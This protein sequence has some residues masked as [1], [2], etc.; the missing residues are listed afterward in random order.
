MEEKDLEKIA[1]VLQQ[2]TNHFESQGKVFIAAFAFK[3]NIESEEYYTNLMGTSAKDVD[4]YSIVSRWT[5][6]AC[7][8]VDELDDKPWKN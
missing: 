3:E 4:Y 1:E 6:R 7:Q 2:L 8:I 5:N